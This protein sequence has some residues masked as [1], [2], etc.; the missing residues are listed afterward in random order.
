MNSHPCVLCGYPTGGFQPLCR[1]C[2]LSHRTRAILRAAKTGM[3]IA[4]VVLVLYALYHLYCF[5]E[6]VK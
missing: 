5:A 4:G 2:R 6:G 3:E 1:H